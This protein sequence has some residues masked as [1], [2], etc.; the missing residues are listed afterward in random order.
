M[1]I[2][3]RADGLRIV[4]Q[5]EHARVAGA[6]AA[7]WGNEDF[8]ASVET[9][10]LT[11]AATR[12][13]DGWRE[14]DAA[15]LVNAEEGRP[16]QFLEVPLTDTAGPYGNGVDAIYDDDVRAGVLASLHRAGLWSARWGM[17]D[18]PPS[19]IR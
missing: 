13:D 11:I 10:S 1:L 12:H 5:V 8:P 14:L 2:S 15:P 19:S 18:S 16:A 7:L 6:M 3:S 17:H 9:D 4:T